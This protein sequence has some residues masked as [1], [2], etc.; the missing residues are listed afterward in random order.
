MELQQQLNSILSGN[1]TITESQ[2]D[3]DWNVSRQV[4]SVFKEGDPTT[5]QG[6]LFQWSVTLT[7]EEVFS[8]VYVEP[9]VFQLAPI[10]PCPT[11]V[12]H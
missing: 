12:C 9:P 8:H 10:A 5:S 11:I 7:M 3:R 4:L 2:N 1:E 6:S